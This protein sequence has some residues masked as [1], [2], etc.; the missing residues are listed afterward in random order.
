MHLFT[1]PHCR[2]RIRRRAKWLTRDEA[3]RQLRATRLRMNSLESTGVCRVFN[4]E[5]HCAFPLFNFDQTASANEQTLTP[6]KLKKLENDYAENT[7]DWRNLNRSCSVCSNSGF[8]EMVRTSEYIKHW[9][10]VLTK[11]N[12]ALVIRAVQLVLQ[13]SIAVIDVRNGGTGTSARLSY[14]ALPEIGA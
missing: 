9:C 13:E 10:W 8:S 11:L 3:R 14:L 6:A 7:L 1:W 2:K 12:L 5:H 4:F